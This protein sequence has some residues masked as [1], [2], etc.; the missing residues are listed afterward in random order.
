MP[1]GEGIVF[2]ERVVN[3]LLNDLLGQKSANHRQ[4]AI[5][6]TLPVPV[7]LDP[8]WQKMG[9]LPNITQ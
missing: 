8:L 9:L 4:Q 5:F 3:P 7:D 1:I 2:Y 6:S